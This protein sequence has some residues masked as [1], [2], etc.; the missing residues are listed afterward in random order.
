MGVCTDPYYRNVEV[1]NIPPSYMLYVYNSQWLSKHIFLQQGNK[2]NV[3]FENLFT[4]P[5]WFK[6]LY[7][8]YYTLNFKKK[9]NLF[10]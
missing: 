3:S 9:L 8:S 2:S 4:Q 6:I 5:C 10:P 1:V 7:N